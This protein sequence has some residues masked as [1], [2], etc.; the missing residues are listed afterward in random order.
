VTKQSPRS[1]QR[2]RTRAQAILTTKTHF[3]IKQ[4]NF[5]LYKSCCAF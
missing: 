1:L 4:S 2:R 3:E 5:S